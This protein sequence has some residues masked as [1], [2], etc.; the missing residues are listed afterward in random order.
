MQ[1]FFCL[2]TRLVAWCVWRVCPRVAIDLLYDMKQLDALRSL[3]SQFL[4]RV[5]RDAEKVDDLLTDAER[6][7]LWS[8]AIMTARISR[9]NDVRPTALIAIV[10]KCLERDSKHIRTIVRTA[11][12]GER[13]LEYV[14]PGPIDPSS[15][16]WE[17]LV[18]ELQSV[19]ASIVTYEAIVAIAEQ[20]GVELTVESFRRRTTM[21]LDD[22]RRGVLDKKHYLTEAFRSA[23]HVHEFDTRPV[24]D[25]LLVGI[26]V[27]LISL[28]VSLGKS[29]GVKLSQDALSLAADRLLEQGQIEEAMVALRESGS[30]MNALSLREYAVDHARKGN[31]DAAMKLLLAAEELAVNERIADSV[32][33]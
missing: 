24:H 29:Y 18:T 14:E 32:H 26:E 17:Y 4:Y 1:W 6:C 3:S 9:D 11:I 10:L 28:C 27:G 33:R 31:A 19:S 22:L 2:C 30:P 5:L 15:D 16:D 23:A 8:Y 20:A 21:M 25:C 13:W 7:N 12:A